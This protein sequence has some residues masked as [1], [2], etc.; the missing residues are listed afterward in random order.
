M[1]RKKDLTGIEIRHRKACRTKS[2]TDHD[3][4]CRPSFRPSVFDERTQKPVRGSACKELDAAINWRIQKIAALNRG[5]RHVEDRTTILEATAELLDRLER[6]IE[7]TRKGKR[8]KPATVRGCEQS[9]RIHILPVLG[10]KRV[11]EVE[12]HHVQDVVD[13][14]I[15]DGF[16]G[17]TI[18]NAILPLRIIY[19]RALAR[20][21]VAHNPARELSLPAVDTEIRRVATATEVALLLSAVP[22]RDRPIWATAF[23]AGLRYGELRALLAEDIALETR[24]I[25]VRSGWDPKLGRQTPKSAAG[26]RSVP[27]IG[28]LRPYLEAALAERSSGLVFGTE[29][30]VPFQSQSVQDRADKCWKRAGLERMTLHECRHTFAS[31][32][33]AA[34]VNAKTLQVYM[35]HSTIT[36][37]LDLYGHLFPGAERDFIA[38]ADRYLNET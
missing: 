35:G 1:A 7:L 28:R 13:A 14:M 18:R 19:G 29:P 5:E 17:S 20:T 27:I 3:C 2:K 26:V 9:L 22:E 21:R 8:Y 37:T 25:R 34:G 33:I 6:G 11:T 10:R 32:M 23:Y 16:S 12:R 4:V 31:L 36:T 38:L 24:L 30:D 15:A